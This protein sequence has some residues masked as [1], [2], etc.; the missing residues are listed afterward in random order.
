M[1]T[2]LDRKL[3][4]VDIMEITLCLKTQTIDTVIA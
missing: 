1:E 2:A 3:N 4:I